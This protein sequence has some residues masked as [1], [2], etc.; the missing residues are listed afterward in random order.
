[1]L[2]ASAVLAKR[3]APR[4]RDRR[5]TPSSI[6]GQSNL[7][8]MLRHRLFQLKTGALRRRFQTLHQQ[9]IPVPSQNSSFILSARFERKT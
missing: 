8:A 4:R 6:R 9:N 2:L 7:P 1:M 5:I 3:A